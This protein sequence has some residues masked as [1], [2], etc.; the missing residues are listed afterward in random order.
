MRIY[1]ENEDWIR[2][3]RLQGVTPQHVWWKQQ[4]CPQ[5]ISLIHGEKTCSWIWVCNPEFF[6]CKKWFLKLRLILSTFFDKGGI[7]LYKTALVTKRFAIWSKGVLFC[8]CPQLYFFVCLG[9]NS[10]CRKWYW[11]LHRFIFESRV[12]QILRLNKDQYWITVATVNTP[13]LFTILPL[14][15]L[16]LC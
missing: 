1:L 2:P 5:G 12:A 3:D 7:W 8:L 14:E 13:H 6:F 11:C 9:A 4:K 16:S 10:C 15:L